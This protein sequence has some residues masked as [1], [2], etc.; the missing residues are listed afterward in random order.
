MKE[1]TDLLNRSKLKSSLNNIE[2]LL[3]SCYHLKARL[4]H[5]LNISATPSVNDFLNMS[6]SEQDAISDKNTAIIKDT[7]IGKAIEHLEHVC[8]ALEASLAEKGDSAEDDNE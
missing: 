8:E 7:S 6:E 3:D 5:A 1:Y 4:T 2:G